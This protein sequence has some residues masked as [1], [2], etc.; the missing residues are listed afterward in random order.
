M[1]GTETKSNPAVSIV[2]PVYNAEPF[3]MTS[4]PSAQSQTVDDIEIICVDDASTDGSANTLSNFQRVDSRITVVTLERNAG[5]SRA[6]NVGIGQ[7]QGEYVFFLDAD[8]SMPADALQR[9]L[10]AASSANVDMVV[11]KYLW[12]KEAPDKDSLQQ[13]APTKKQK[14]TISSMSESPFLQTVPGCH[15]CNLYLRSFL[16]REALRYD[17]DL[18]FGEDQLF[19]A[20]A[21]IRSRRVGIVDDV[22][23]YYHHYRSRSLTQSLPSLKNLLDD[24]EYQHRIAEEFSA[25]GLK[26][27]SLRF[28]GNWVYPLREYWAK[29][30]QTLSECEA[31]AV[32]SKLRWLVQEHG[33]HPWGPS[34]PQPYR[35]LLQLV[36]DGKDKQAY[37]YLE[38]ERLS[39]ET[40]STV[41][42]NKREGSSPSRN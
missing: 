26:E 3:L 9:L 8:D 14:I 6:R 39:A 23:Y 40:E 28:L 42:L 22:V 25:A 36:L 20:K 19:Q 32:F 1:F 37:Q 18:T 38:D 12:F 31:G 21:M 15:C 24:I 29:I 7:A 17:I 27:A 4:I 34:T 35:E 16:D 2:V 13:P 30:P 33:V 10:L 5:A 11:G 41:S